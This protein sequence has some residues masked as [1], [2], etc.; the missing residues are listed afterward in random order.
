MRA[1][2]VL[3]CL[4]ISLGAVAAAPMAAAKLTVSDKAIG[5]VHRFSLAACNSALGVCVALTAV[6][7]AA[8]Q[9]DAATR[10]GD[11]PSLSLDQSRFADPARLRTADPMPVPRAP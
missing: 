9:P 7:I 3:V 11:I 6:G 8:D 4:L 10:P 1:R 2:S 5:S